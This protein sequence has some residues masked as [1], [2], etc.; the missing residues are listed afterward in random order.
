MYKPLK[1]AIQIPLCMKKMS[2]PSDD[3]DYTGS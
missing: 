1:Y 2:V 3:L